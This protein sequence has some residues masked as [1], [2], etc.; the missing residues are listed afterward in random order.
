[1]PLLVIGSGAA[2]FVDR[3]T[4]LADIV[5]AIGAYFDFANS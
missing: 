5:P 1:V 4:T 2:A 3:V